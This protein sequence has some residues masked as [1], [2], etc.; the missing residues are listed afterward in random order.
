MSEHEGHGNA[1]SLWLGDAA[2]MRV[3]PA[4]VMAAGGYYKWAE[5]WAEAI[6]ASD[7]L[8]THDERVRAQGWSDALD[9]VDVAAADPEV[10]VSSWDLYVIRGITARLRA[11]CPGAG[12]EN[13]GGNG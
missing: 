6:L 12:D 3:A 1:L 5:A 10:A 4:S 2:T 8:A 9:E 13:E 11:A 7:W